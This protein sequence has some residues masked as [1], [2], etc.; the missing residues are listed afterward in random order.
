MAVIFLVKFEERSEYGA[1]LGLLD[2][3]F[4]GFDTVYKELDMQRKSCT[5]EF[6]IG[7]VQLMNESSKPI[8]CLAEELGV[9]ENNLYNWQADPRESTISSVR[10]YRDFLQLVA[11]PLKPRLPD[12]GG[13]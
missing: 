4:I 11:T 6:K 5:R 9:S 13:F 7:A 8:C 2:T 1:F 10:L 12:L 3:L